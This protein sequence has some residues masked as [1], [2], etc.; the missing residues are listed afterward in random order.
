MQRAYAALGL[1]YGNQP[2]TQLQPQVQGQQPAQPQAHQQM[3]TINALGANQMN[4]PTGGITTDQQA[5]LI[6]E[7]ALPTSL[8]TNK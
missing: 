8:G 3:R 6:S 2:Q 4:L 1:P 5:S 7:T